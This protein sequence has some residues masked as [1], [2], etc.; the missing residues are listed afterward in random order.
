MSEARRHP[1][2]RISLPV[3]V[4]SVDPDRNARTGAAVFRAFNARTVDISDGGLALTALEDL[5]SGRRVRVA[6]TLPDG[7]SVE[8][9]GRIVWLEPARQPDLPARM[10]VA[11]AQTTPGL[12]PLAESAVT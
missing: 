10:G 8:L 11:L 1:R 9:A 5:G 6:L 12:T 7:H 2:T 3:R 4:A